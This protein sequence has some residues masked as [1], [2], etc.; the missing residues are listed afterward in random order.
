MVSR[1]TTPS[2]F[3]ELRPRLK[4]LLEMHRAAQTD[5]ARA[6]LVDL[7]EDVF[8]AT[9]WHVARD[10]LDN[11]WEPGF[12]APAAGHPHLRLVKDEDAA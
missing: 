6:T 8:L 7:F 3:T 5:E 11:G 9:A 10:L 4:A 12:G 1:F 2:E